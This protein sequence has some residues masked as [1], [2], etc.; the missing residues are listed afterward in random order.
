MI[1]LYIYAFIAIVVTGYFMIDMLLKYRGEENIET[2]IISIV[3]GMMWPLFV[4]WLIVEVIS[5]FNIRRK[6]RR[7]RKGL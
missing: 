3:T 7:L 5:W 4:I 1:A 6:E 2:V